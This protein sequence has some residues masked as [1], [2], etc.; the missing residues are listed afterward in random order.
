VGWGCYKHEIDAGSEVW[1]RALD[2][3]CDQKLDTKPLTWGRDR[4]ICPLCYV[5]LEH[6]YKQLQI[7]YHKLQLLYDKEMQAKENE[8]YENAIGKTY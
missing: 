1:Q 2:E 5:E 6:N 8:K 3:L 7:N 4:A